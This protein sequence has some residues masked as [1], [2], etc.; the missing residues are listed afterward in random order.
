M[1]IQMKATVFASDDDKPA[2]KYQEGLIYEV[3]EFLSGKLIR[4]GHAEKVIEQAAA[5]VLETKVIKTKK[6]GE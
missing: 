4:E 2:Q 3:G 1:K 6:K 5:S